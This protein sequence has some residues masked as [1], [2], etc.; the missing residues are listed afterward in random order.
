MVAMSDDAGA[1]LEVIYGGAHRTRPADIIEAESFIG[2]KS[3][4]AKGKRIT[5]H[6]VASLRFVEP[7]IPPEEPSALSI[8]AGEEEPEADFDENALHSEE[9]TGAVVEP[10]DSDSDSVPDVLDW[11]D[12]EDKVNPSQLNLF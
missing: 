9:D 3:H 12:V 4:R 6:E 7:L 11:E 2:I 5:T 1:R 8:L 10:E